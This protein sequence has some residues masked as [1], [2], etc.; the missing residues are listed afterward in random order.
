MSSSDPDQRCRARAVASLFGCG[1]RGCLGLVAIL[2]IGLAAVVGL[3]W[4]FRIVAEPWSVPLGGRPT[5]TGEWVGTIRTASSLRFG[6]ALKLD[7]YT[8]SSGG[9][10]RSNIKID[11]SGQLC[12]RRG[13]RYDYGISGSTADWGGGS[14]RLTLGSRDTGVNGS[15]WGFQV[16]WQGDQ[17]T[18]TGVN[19]GFELDDRPVGGRSHL[20]VVDPLVGELR[21]APLGALDAV[22]RKLVAERR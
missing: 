14:S 2:A 11:G 15:G 5:L 20:I 22:C 8:S 18:L 9:R 16:R 10:G 3:D 13:D 21:R 4:V 17:L 7:Y 19:D 1:P 6:L 12:N